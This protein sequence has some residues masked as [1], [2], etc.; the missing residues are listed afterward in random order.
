MLCGIPP[1]YNENTDRM[2]ELIKHAELRF[3]KKIKISE[4]AQDL[5]Y[6]FLD[7]DV[8][9]RLGSKEGLKQFKNH[10]FFSKIDFDLI[11]Q[12]KIISPFLPELSGKTDVRNFDVE[13]TMETVD[14]SV[15]PQKNLDLIKKNAEAFKEF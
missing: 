11:L 15:I 2:Y 12:K 5:I 9:T 3:P 6:K 10:S 7:R 14:Q 1:F 4:D 8:N 13:F